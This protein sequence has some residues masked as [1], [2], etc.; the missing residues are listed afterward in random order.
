MA[1]SDSILTLRLQHK[2]SIYNRSFPSIITCGIGVIFMNTD[3]HGFLKTQEAQA[4]SAKTKEFYY[5]LGI[6][7][8]RVFENLNKEEIIEEFKKID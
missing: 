3:P 5:L 6:K 7:D 2:S 8:I 4:Y 1:V